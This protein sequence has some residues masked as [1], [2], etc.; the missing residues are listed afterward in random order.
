MDPDPS[1]DKH[2]CKT[3]TYLLRGGHSLIDVLKGLRGL[4]LLFLLLDLWAVGRNGLHQLL[5][6]LT[7]V[8]HD[9]DATSVQLK[10]DRGHGPMA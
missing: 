5:I 2:W 7:G 8:F 9:D 4:W 10:T 1:F 6:F 3:H